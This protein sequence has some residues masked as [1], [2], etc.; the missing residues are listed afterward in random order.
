[1]SAFT[2]MTRDEA[3]AIAKRDGKSHVVTIRMANGDASIPARSYREAANWVAMQAD[4]MYPGTDR[5]E[6]VK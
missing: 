5:I 3:I 4:Y 2:P 1:M 6:E